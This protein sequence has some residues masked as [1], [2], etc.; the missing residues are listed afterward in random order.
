MEYV[1][2]LVN[3]AVMTDGQSQAVMLMNIYQ[4]EYVITVHKI[5]IQ[6][7]VQQALMIVEQHVQQDIVM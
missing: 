4:V 3:Q 6:T 5:I 2:K 1:Q 7:L